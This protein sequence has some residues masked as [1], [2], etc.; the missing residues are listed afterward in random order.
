MYLSSQ[1]RFFNAGHESAGVTAPATTWFLA[2]GATGP[3]FDLFVLIANP[4]DVP[5]RLDVNYLLSDGTT[6]QKPYT[7][8]PNSRRTIWVDWEDFS[9]DGSG[10]F[11]LADVQVST[12]VTSA[13]GVPVVVERAMWWPGGVTEWYEAHNSAG[14]TETGTLWALAEGE[15]SAATDTYVLIANTSDR[16]GKARVTLLFEDGTSAEREFGLEA[17]SRKTVPVATDFPE[18][19]GR[20]FGALIESVGD[21]PVEL[22]VER[23]MYTSTGGVWWSAGSNAVAIRLR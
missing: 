17:T 21:S 13:N 14:V 3:V 22:V 16:K 11:A 1:G 9:A 2:E 4:N 20:R 12:L 6:V 18:A 19:A 7:V 23:A 10:D 15:Q 5:A 8:E